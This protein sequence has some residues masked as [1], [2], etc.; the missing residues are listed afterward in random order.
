MPFEQRPGTGALFKNR[1]HDNPN[2]PTLKGNGLLQL[3]NGR[4]VEVELAAWTKE[5]A[6]AGRWLSLTIKLKGERRPNA[7]DL[8]ADTPIDNDEMP[9]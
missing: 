6:K 5:S 8:A 4:V 1:H 3:D 7:Q 2:A 9:W